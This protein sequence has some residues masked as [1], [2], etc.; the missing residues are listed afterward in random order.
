MR[1]YYVEIKNF[2][3]M[4]KHLRCSILTK[5]YMKHDLNYRKICIEKTN[6]EHTENIS[7]ILGN[8]FAFSILF[9]F[10]KYSITSMVYL[11]NQEKQEINK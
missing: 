3:N 10:S 6:R 7:I 2:H 4:E 11:Y 5:F 9:M 1:E 8:F